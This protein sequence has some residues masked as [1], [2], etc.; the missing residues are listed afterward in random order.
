M[1]VKSFVLSLLASVGISGIAILLIAFAMFRWNLRGVGILVCVGLTYALANF[2]GGFL[3][4]KCAKS[5]RFLWGIG[6]GT[7]YF[8][9]Y[10]LVG[11]LLKTNDTIGIGNA[12]LTYLLT[13]AGGMAG[14]MVARN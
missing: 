12:A 14:G 6:L 8:L 13:A 3:V 4:G 1:R 7:T 2:I 5:R 10:L 9:C 11:S